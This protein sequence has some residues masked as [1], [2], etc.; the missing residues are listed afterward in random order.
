[1]RFLSTSLGV[2]T[3]CRFADSAEAWGGNGCVFKI[4]YARHL[5]HLNIS[6]GSDEEE[7]ILPRGLIFRKITWLKTEI[8]ELKI[9][10]SMYKGYTHFMGLE[11]MGASNVT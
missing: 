8:E 9:S 11:V 3:A 4:L 10:T 1:M 7:V 6:R 5:P 2:A